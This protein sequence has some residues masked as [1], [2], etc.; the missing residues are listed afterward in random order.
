MTKA[1]LIAQATACGLVGAAIRRP[2]RGLLVAAL[3]ACVIGLLGATLVPIGEREYVRC[4]SSDA[5]QWCASS[6][7]N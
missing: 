7:V 5:P 3:V 1:G 4:A 2:S 6:F